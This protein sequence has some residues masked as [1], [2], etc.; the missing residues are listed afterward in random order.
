M[1]SGKILSFGAAIVAALCTG[2][3]CYAQQA[4]LTGLAD[5]AFGTLATAVDQSISRSIVVCSYRNKPQDLPYSVRAV[6]SAA[7]GSFEL[8]SSTGTLRYD[9]QWSDLPGQAG[10]VMLQPGVPAP[11]FGNAATGFACQQSPSTASL[12]VT[13]RAADLAAAQAGDYV[14]LLQLTIAPE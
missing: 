10:G 13:I 14:G 9:V 12:T 8:Q 5:T 1:T 6:G 11:G 3:P 4:Q 2:T 7:N